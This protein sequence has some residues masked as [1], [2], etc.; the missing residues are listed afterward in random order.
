[1]AVEQREIIGENS[2]ARIAPAW[3]LLR[4]HDDCLLALAVSTRANFQE[5]AKRKRNKDAK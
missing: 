1:M 5:F 4:E 2:T 3:L